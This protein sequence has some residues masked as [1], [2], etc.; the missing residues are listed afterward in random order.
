[1]FPAER[2]KLVAV[3]G[4]Y[5]RLVAECLFASFGSDLYCIWLLSLC[6]ACVSLSDGHSHQQ[7]LIIISSLW[8]YM[9]VSILANKTLNRNS[10][11]LLTL[12]FMDA[13]KPGNES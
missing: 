3:S 8:K 6:L 2:M 10:S 13:A 4:V 1:M 5:V 9:D 11:L 7:L 12:C